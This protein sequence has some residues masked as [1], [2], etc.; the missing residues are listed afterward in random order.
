MK[1]ENIMKELGRMNVTKEMLD[2]IFDKEHTGTS[3][4]DVIGAKI[5]VTGFTLY[6]NEDDN[7]YHL[8]F[9]GDSG[10]GNTEDFFTGSQVFIKDFIRMAKNV[11]DGESFLITVCEGESKKGRKY[12][13]IDEAPKTTASNSEWRNLDI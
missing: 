10:Q 12:L 13:Y 3:V 8:K 5:T 6:I 7:K 2:E 9:F 11:P 1:G 4:K